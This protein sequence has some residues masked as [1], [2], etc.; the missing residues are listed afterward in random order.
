MSADKIEVLRKTF[1][2]FGATGA[3]DGLIDILTDDVVYRVTVGPGTP[4]SGDFV[5][6]DGVRGYFAGMPEAVTHLSF[7]VYDFLANDDTAVVTG[8]EGLKVTKTGV[9]FETDW[10][11]VCKYRG[12]LIASIVV[13]ENLAPL[14]AAY[15]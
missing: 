6:K 5:G 10:A 12:D 13:I 1:A 9:E 7:A 11:V 2:D 15:A 4:L 14:E 8:H 3:V